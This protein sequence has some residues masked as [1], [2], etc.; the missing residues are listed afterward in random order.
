MEV[1]WRKTLSLFRPSYELGLYAQ[2]EQQLG[3]KTDILIKTI[4]TLLEKRNRASSAIEG[5]NASL[6]PCL[7]VQK[8]VTQN[9]L[10]LFKAYY[11]LRTRRG[12][13]DIKALQL[14]NVLPVKLWLTGF[15]S[16]TIQRQHKMH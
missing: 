11:N 8:G 4:E 1:V 12:G 14:T 7:Y 9:F 10:E 2:L 5:F 3:T 6:R 13:G 16:W 15:P